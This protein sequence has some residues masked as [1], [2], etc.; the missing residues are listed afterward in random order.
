M[1]VDALER[2]DVNV[3][4]SLRYATAGHGQVGGTPSE[5]HAGMQ[6]GGGVELVNPFGWAERYRISGLLG[7]ERR[8]LSARYD[9][10][11]FFRWHVPTE[12]LLFDDRTRVAD[13][14]GLG[15]RV[16]GAVFAQVRRWSGSVDGRR[17]RERFMMQ[18]G[19]SIRRVDYTDFTR[20]AMNVSGRRAGLIY[21]L[22]GDTRDSITDPRRGVL[23]STGNELDLVGLGSERNYLKTY[24]QLF[25][26]IPL[27]PHLTWAQAYRIGVVTGNDPF[28]LLEDR[29]FAGGSTSVRGFAESALGPRA[30]DGVAIGGQASAILNQELR[31]PLW[32]RL[33]AGVFYDSGNTFAVAGE[34]DPRALR[35]S[36]G[37]GLRLMFPFGP[38]RVDWAHVLDPRAGE[39]PSRV[40]LRIGHAF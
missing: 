16:T 22:I 25:V 5:S 29:F 18:W 20:R 23:W 35:H 38:V 7:Q 26:Y 4:Y 17:L 36:A 3:E 14:P 11:T 19:Y 24:G 8:Q 37:V 32:K 28:L 9:T 21:S 27:L 15:D 1:V 40:T 12:V 10:A 2:S 34:L 30:P 31:F 33:H 13:A 6:V 39:R